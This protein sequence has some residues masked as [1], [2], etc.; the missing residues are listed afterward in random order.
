MHRMQTRKLT[1]ELQ[2]LL[3]AQSAALMSGGSFSGARPNGSGSPYL[4]SSKRD[5]RKKTISLQEARN[6][7]L[8]A[9]RA[10][11]EIKDV[12]EDVYASQAGERESLVKTVEGWGKKRGLLEGEIHNIEEGDE[13]QRLEALREEKSEIEDELHQLR[14]RLSKLENKHSSIS[15]QLSEL[16]STIS[17]KT[18]SYQVSLASLKQKTANFLSTHRYASPATATE[19]WTLEKAA[20]DEK[21]Q[22]AKTEGD[23]LRDGIV[24][25]EDALS[26]V[27]GF[28]EKLRAQLMTSAG[29]P[30]KRSGEGSIKE[31]IMHD[32]EDVIDQLEQR[33]KL[34]EGR[35][36]KLLVC[37][38]GA[39]LQVFLEAREVMKRS[40]GV[41]P[42][43]SVSTADITKSS[44]FEDGGNQHDEVESR[45]SKGSG[46]TAGSSRRSV[47]STVGGPVR[48]SRKG[49]PRSTSGASR[50]IASP[51]GASNSILDQ[52]DDGRSG[53]PGD[54]KKE[55]SDCG[56]LLL[57]VDH[58]GDD[59]KDY[60]PL[61][62]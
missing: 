40:L 6:G 30:G 44:G 27:A 58:G 1:E 59:S 41:V 23:A 37:C 32:I 9:M 8:R 15:M 48:S 57:T 4:Q 55:E 10:L 56:D 22:Q 46:S 20:L 45:S 21:K 17:S 36:W 16:E 12:E 50:R 13:G 39:E 43:S 18:S 47:F 49:G 25:W 52:S 53:S 28:E 14:L 54:A 3:D 11:A 51:S 19:S 33:L 7:V 5:G 34:A 26:L 38:V 31:K 2:V 29:V 35:N 61:D 24:M 60:S 62:D 42:A